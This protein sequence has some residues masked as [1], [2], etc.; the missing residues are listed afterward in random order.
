[1]IKSS[2]NHVT[3]LH[4]SSIFSPLKVMTVILASQVSVNMLM[5]FGD[6]SHRVVGNS[7]SEQTIRHYLCLH[8]KNVLV[9]SLRY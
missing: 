7:P 4:N 2:V 6:M 9:S 8:I 5:S 1:M 3:K